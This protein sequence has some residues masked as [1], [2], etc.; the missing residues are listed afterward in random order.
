MTK[1]ISIHTLRVEGD[2]SSL[3]TPSC[4]PYIS[5]HTLRVEGDVAVNMRLPNGAEFQSTPSAW[6]VTP[7][8]YQQSCPKIFQST[9]SAWRVTMDFPLENFRSIFQST[10]SAWRVTPRPS[11]LTAKV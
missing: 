11:S 3:G 9:P 2:V 6:R 7:S 4:V 5:I 10:P 8:R 1:R